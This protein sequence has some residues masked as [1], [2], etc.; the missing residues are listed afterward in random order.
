MAND[1]I[2][3]KELETLVRIADGHLADQVPIAHAYRLLQLGLIQ[4]ELRGL[5]ATPRGH[6]VA[7]GMRF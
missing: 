4:Q 2:N 6:I 5:K 3:N 7:K 1:D